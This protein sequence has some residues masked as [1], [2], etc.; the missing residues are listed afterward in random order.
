MRSFF[1]PD[2]WFWRGFGRFADYFIL[3][4][5]WMVCCVPLVTA[6][7]ASIALYD[8][9]AHCLRYQDDTLARRFFST[10]KKELLRGVLLTLLWA[11]VCYLLNVGY[12]IICQL[13]GGDAAWTVFSIVYFVTLFVPLGV[14][15]WAVA[16]ESRFAYRFGELHKTALAFTFAHLP[17]TAAIVVIFVV[18][19][20]VVI[21][22]P[23]FV[24]IL[25]AAMAHLQS[26]FIEKVFAKY[27]PE[28]EETEIAEI[29]A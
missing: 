7:T 9:V 4:M 13:G 19:L 10:F 20:N 8:T 18:V 22:F 27:M 2:N 14:I 16:L 25:P 28:E 11:V 23:F 29:E 21:N 1:N 24:M 26:V 6:G 17:Q 5:M 12:Q 15:C 3:S